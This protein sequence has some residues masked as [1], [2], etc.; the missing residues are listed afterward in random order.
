[1]NGW[2]ALVVDLARETLQSPRGAAGRLI[3]FDPPTEARWLA[4]L[5]VAVL[6]VLETR[7]ALLLMPVSEV[8]GVFAIL[9]N[10]WLG[11]PAQVGSLVLIAAA[12]AVIGGMFGGRGRFNDALLLV[13]WLEFLL[14]VAQAVQMLV[15]LTLPPVGALFAIAVLLGFIWLMVQ[16]T[17]ALHGFSNLFKVFL[18][19]VAGFV[20][21][22][23][24]LALVFGVLGITPP[25]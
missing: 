6:A 24:V 5:L 10:P 25:V 8:G 14:T 23:T 13:V 18:G 21:I 1:M 11:V 12:M 16:F 17:A 19:M 15:M 2:R 20:A 7:L 9:A 4:L 3:A 22:V